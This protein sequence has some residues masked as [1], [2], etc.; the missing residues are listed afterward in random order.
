MNQN[1]KVIPYE[2]VLE[3]ELNKE[4]YFIP[5]SEISKKLNPSNS[6]ICYGC[7]CPCLL[8]GEIRSSIER[9]SYLYVHG[10]GNSGCYECMIT[11]LMC[12]ICWPLSPCLSCYIYRQERLLHNIYNQNRP[13]HKSCKDLCCHICCWSY[14]LYQYY[15]YINKKKSDGLLHYNWA[16][17]IPTEENCP[18][19]NVSN[20]MAVLIIGPSQCGKT[21]LL[22][23]LTGR[24]ISN[25]GDPSFTSEEIRI[26]LKES[27]LS[28]NELQ[29]IEYWDIP[30]SKL[31]SIPFITSNVK[32]VL[33]LYDCNSHNSFRDMKEIFSDIYC[34]P[35]LSN[36]SYLCIAAKDDYQFIRTTQRNGP[37][38]ESSTL[39]EESVTARK[40]EDLGPCS[41]ELKAGKEWARQRGFR[42][43]P[44]SSRY[45]CGIT[46]ILKTIRR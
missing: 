8:F 35:T 17:H 34:L 10:I 36:A 19:Q 45:N 16:Y 6:S 13:Q 20:D 4:N 30:L 1:K 22:M 40:D 46:S 39:E 43:I 23:K 5:T 2:E 27:F 9:D 12:S 29:V 31:D 18:P 24:R 3:F 14:P 25:Y 42:F 37:P 11:A 44:I 7:F 21:E 41:K 28:N 26:G 15:H 32:Y 38:D 33:L